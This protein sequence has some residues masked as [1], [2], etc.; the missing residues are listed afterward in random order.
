[1]VMEGLTKKEIQQGIQNLK[2][3]KD[4]M[5]WP[6]TAIRFRKLCKEGFKSD[7][8]CDKAFSEYRL[9]RSLQTSNYTHPIYE[10]TARRTSVRIGSAYLQDNKVYEIFSAYFT[11][12]QHE[13]MSGA[14]FS[15]YVPH[16]SVRTGLNREIHM[17][18]MKK[19]KSILGSK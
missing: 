13:Y 6:P 4:F 16:N 1:M 12:V 19:I 15:R 18:N 9:C 14:K 5:D 7:I 10:E 11:S 2:N 8:S 3:T 17:S